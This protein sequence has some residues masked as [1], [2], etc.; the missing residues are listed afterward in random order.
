MSRR[1]SSAASV[2]PLGAVY[3]VLNSSRTFIQSALSPFQ[4]TLLPDKEALPINESL[5][6]TFA[7]FFCSSP[8][9]VDQTDPL[10]C[11]SHDLY[12][13][14]QPEEL[15]YGCKSFAR[16]NENDLPTTPLMLVYRPIELTCLL[17]S[18]ERALTVSYS[19]ILSQ[20]QVPEYRA[21]LPGMIRAPILCVRK[22]MS[23][24][25]LVLSEKC[26]IVVRI[27]DFVC[28]TV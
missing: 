27:S 23:V 8:A 22:T 2:K 10:A 1:A 9:P 18:F 13:E 21:D 16:Q 20:A 26:F 25:R 24:L 15:H 17:K 4:E 7:G 6:S 28:W 5:A 11:N 19:L 12:Q 14:E 3:I